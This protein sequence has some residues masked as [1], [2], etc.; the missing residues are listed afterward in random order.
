M[1]VREIQKCKDTTCMEETVWLVHT[2]FESAKPDLTVNYGTII[3]VFVVIKQ[4]HN[5]S[6]FLGAKWFRDEGT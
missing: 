5:F 1:N 3:D 2:K 6:G 4:L